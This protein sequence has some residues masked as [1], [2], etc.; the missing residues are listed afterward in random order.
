MVSNFEIG[1][2]DFEVALGARPQAVEDSIARQHS[3]IETPSDGKGLKG[4][5]KTTEF[6]SY[7]LLYLVAFFLFLVELPSQ[8]LYLMR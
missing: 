4:M 5:S 8:H 7:L 1:V 2:S 3:I 6:L